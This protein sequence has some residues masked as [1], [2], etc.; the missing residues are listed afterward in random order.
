[1]VVVVFNRHCLRHLGSSSLSL[2][3]VVFDRLCC[4]WSSSLGVF[5]ISGRLCR[6]WSLS[7]VVVFVIFR[8]R[9]LLSS[10]VVFVI[11]RCRH[12]LLPLSS[13]VLVI[14]GRRRL[15]S[16]SS[17]PVVVFFFGLV[18]SLLICFISIFEQ[19]VSGGDAGEDEAADRQSSEEN[20][21]RS[22]RKN[23]RESRQV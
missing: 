5:V 3:V 7:S 1:M 11:F 20:V 22:L 12:L 2:V 8:C 21:P 17:F 15:R 19:R 10:S 23:I 13:V 9:H 16:L 6:L 18:C 14:F 4:L